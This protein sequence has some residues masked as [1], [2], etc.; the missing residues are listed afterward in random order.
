VSVLPNGLKPVVQKAGSA[1]AVVFR[2]AYI[3]FPS[4]KNKFIADLTCKIVFLMLADYWQFS[5][6]AFT[7]KRC[8]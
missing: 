3:A 6:S 8:N 1:G 7:E 4:S 5:L 2:G